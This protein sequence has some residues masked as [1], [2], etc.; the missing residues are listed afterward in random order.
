MYSKEFGTMILGNNQC[1][2]NDP[3]VV[4]YLFKYIS[5]YL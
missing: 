1:L 3:K 4:R 5:T 2:L